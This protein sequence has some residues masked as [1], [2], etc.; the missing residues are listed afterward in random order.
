MS[1]ILCENDNQFFT[2]I[3]NLVLK[4]LG[5]RADYRTLTITVTGQH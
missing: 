4:G 3:E 1:I 5:F 2:A